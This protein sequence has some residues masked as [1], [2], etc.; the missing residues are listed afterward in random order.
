M[1]NSRSVDCILTQVGAVRFINYYSL[2]RLRE[3]AFLLPPMNLWRIR[4]IRAILNA[5]NG[6]EE[7]DTVLEIACAS[8]VLTRKLARKLPHSKIIGIDISMEM[9]YAARKAT[10]EPN[11][12]YRTIDFFK[13][14]EQYPLV[15]GMHILH[16]LPLRPFVK[17]LREV[18]SPEGKVILSFTG[19]NAITKMYRRFY[20]IFQGDE[21]YLEDPDSVLRAFREAGF[22]PS[23]SPIDYL[24]GSMLLTAVKR[25]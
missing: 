15:L 14:E 3:L 6:W 11:V 24:E 1:L 18:T 22:A 25:G 8:G 23:L 4:A 13:L 16:M 12:S 9:V 2:P 17:K 10:R 20:R 5:M 19:P 21:V 7:P